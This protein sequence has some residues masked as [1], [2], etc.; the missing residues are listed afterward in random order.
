MYIKEDNR[1]GIKDCEQ[2]RYV[3]GCDSVIIWK[4]YLLVI[5]QCLELQHSRED[6]LCFCCFVC[7]FEVSPTFCASPCLAGETRKGTSQNIANVTS[8]NF[9][10]VL[11]ASCYNSGIRYLICLKCLR[12]TFVPPNTIFWLWIN[13]T[14][15]FNIHT[16]VHRNIFP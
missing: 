16:S 7:L 8:Q 6:R 10:S 14:F 11:D 13:V 3:S 4:L 5:L 1:C 12:A 15:T 9:C 2:L